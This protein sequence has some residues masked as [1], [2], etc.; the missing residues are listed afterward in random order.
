M[1][2]FCW[3]SAGFLLI[4]C[5]FLVFFSNARFLVKMLVFCC[6]YFAGFSN[7]RFRRQVETPWKKKYHRFPPLFP[8]FFPTFSPLFPHFFPAFSRFFFLADFSIPLWAPTPNNG[9]KLP[10]NS[11]PIARFWSRR[12]IFTKVLPRKHYKGAFF[13][14]YFR[15]KSSFE[16]KSAD[17]WVVSGWFLGVFWWFLQTPVIDPKWKTPDISL[18]IHS[19]RAHI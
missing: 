18:N 11:L 10:T 2:V 8:H 4:F 17:F 9:D 15:I 14:A 19:P 3:F 5:W 7:T 6:Y 1:L 13:A 12:K 16:K